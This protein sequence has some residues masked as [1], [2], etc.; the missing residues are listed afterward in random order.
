MNIKKNQNK[1]QII[2]VNQIINKFKISFIKMIYI[3]TFIFVLLYSFSN[4]SSQ[5]LNAQNQTINQNLNQNTTKKTKYYF[6]SNL[7]LNNNFYIS[8]F[9]EFEGV[10]NCCNSFESAFGVGYLF[11]VGLEIAP[12]TSFMGDNVNYYFNLGISD[13]SA[14]YDEERFIGYKLYQEKFEQIITHHILEPKINVVNFDAGFVFKDLLTNDFDLR[15]GVRIS[16]IIS[17]TFTQYEEAL[18]PS[19]FVFENG[20]RIVGEYSGDIQNKALTFFSLN[21]GGVY[22]LYNSGNIKLGPELN[23]NIGLTNIYDKINLKVINSMV[24]VNFSYNLSPDEVIKIE[25][26]VIIKEPEVIE[27]PVE[28]VY[29]LDYQT[30]NKFEIINSKNETKSINTQNSNQID[31]EIL[32]KQYITKYSLKPIIYFGK[33]N[34]NPITKIETIDGKVIDTYDNILSQIAQNSNSINNTPKPNKTN[35]SKKLQLV[36]YKDETQNIE[37]INE[38]FE[39][40]K[41]DLIKINPDISNS[42]IETKII[43][44]NSKKFKNEDLLAENN[45]VEII[46]N[47]T[48]EFID[49]ELINKIDIIKPTLMNNY[50]INFKTNI[51]EF[52]INK[53]NY[54]LNFTLYNLENNTSNKLVSNPLISEKSVN[55]TNNI[56][57]FSYYEGAGKDN[58]KLNYDITLNNNLVYNEDIKYNVIPQND[59]QQKYILNINKK[60]E[61]IENQNIDENTNGVYNE[62]LLALTEFDSDEINILNLNV[63]KT[64]QNALKNNKKIQVI[65]MSDNIGSVEHNKQL[66]IS[67]ANKGKKTIIDYFNKN[68]SQT[69]IKIENLI[70]TDVLNNFYFKNDTP[71]GRTLNRGIIVRIID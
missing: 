14:N 67:R 3:Y 20:K 33:D 12:I 34:I 45:K 48:N 59:I 35:K 64:I 54:Q 65:G 41:N 47:E 2:E 31:I 18:S 58:V 23:F 7:G 8:D 25:E 15:T 52:D 4:L 17:G 49:Y 61:K 21:F 13:I 46:V 55:Y 43:D 57:Y 29:N 26:P 11:N 24:G 39:K 6:D 38:R 71:N 62:Y 28:I 51:P 44:I 60:I 19:N 66:S 63:L 22:Y 56:D 5:D 42:V 30:T 16:S 9:K 37:L 68:N 40:I 69:N 32:E 50:Q 27:E 70:N 36:A 10:E 53:L 1:K